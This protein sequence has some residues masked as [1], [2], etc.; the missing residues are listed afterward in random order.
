MADFLRRD[1]GRNVWTCR[2]DIPAR[3]RH[4][5][6]G[7]KVL[8][9]SLGTTNRAEAKQLAAMVVARWRLQ[10][11]RAG[12]TTDPLRAEA[13]RWRSFIA[14]TATGDEDDDTPILLTD[15]AEQ[16]EREH[17]EAAALLFAKVASGQAVLL[18]A[19][20]DRWLEWRQYPPRGEYQQRLNLKPLLQHFQEVSQVD[21]RAASKFVQDVLTPG[22]SPASVSHMLSTYSQLWRWMRREEIVKGESPWTDQGASPGARRAAVEGAQKRRRGFTEDEA[23][24]FLG[25]L[26]GVGRAGAVDKDVCRL[27]AVT[28]M[29]LEEATSLMVKDVTETASATW[30]NITASKTVSGIRRVPVV[31]DSVRS[32]LR[33]RCA[34]GE[35]AVFMELPVNRFGDRSKA[36]SVRLSGKL[37]AIIKDPAL[38]AAHGFR[39]RCRTKLE[40]A[41]IPLPTADWFMGHARP[42]EGLGRY[43]KPSDEQLLRAARAVPLPS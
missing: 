38:V 8:Q 12:A 40:E 37:R 35:P 14:E 16:V 18:D 7:K 43:S 30:L 23:R 29:R 27:L 36:L 15:R 32:M 22:R 42:G 24:D 21:R 33:S 19:V 3:V 10:F 4:A 26:T 11:K 25:S 2:L 20:A 31:D 41:E 1:P 28:G 39:H 17:G 34:T 13:E 6:D 5:F 9:K